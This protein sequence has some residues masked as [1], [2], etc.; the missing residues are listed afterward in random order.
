VT[1]LARLYIWATYRLYDEFAWAYDTVSWLA[2]FGNWSNWRRSS[3]DHLAGRRVLE[4]GFGTGELLIEMANHELEVVGLEPS[5]AMHR[6][7]ARK[8]AR[9]GVEVPRLCG[10]V[11]AM[12]FADG[13]FDSIVSTFPAGYILEPKTLQE[14]AR[15]L[16]PPDPDA[17]AEGGRLV[18]VGMVVWKDGWLWRR[19]VRLLFGSGGES[20]V[21]RFERSATAAGLHLEV[22]D[23]V[24]RGWHVLVVLATRAAPPQ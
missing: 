5:L 8:V 1:W 4:V 20:A 19:V 24:N 10:V 21:D 22:M 2:S 23:Q 17:G 13:Q 7:A 3:L 11:Q 18:I 12:P 16:R 6:A 14:V 15:L 9:Q